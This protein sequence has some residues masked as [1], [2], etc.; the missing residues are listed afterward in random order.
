MIRRWLELSS[1]RR[2]ALVRAV[3]EL[4]RARIVFACVPAQALIRDLEA[5]STAD[6]GPGLTLTDGRVELLAWSIRAAAPRVPW[7]SDCLIQVL[8][9]ERVLRRWGLAPRFYLGVENDRERGFSAHV[10]LEHGGM[11][12]TGGPVDRLTRM[13][14][15]AGS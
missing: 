5:R 2:R 8:A 11:I 15:Q 1:P 3:A 9:A 4:L 14:G 12:V 6:A 13:M 10:W 7:R